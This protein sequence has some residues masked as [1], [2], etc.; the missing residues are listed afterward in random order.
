M[1]RSELFLTFGPA[2]E[3]ALLGNVQSALS[4][5]IGSCDYTGLLIEAGQR[6][7]AQLVCRDPAVVCGQPWFDKVFEVLDPTATV[8]WHVAEGSVVEPGTV[9]CEIDGFA[10]PMMTAERSAMNFLQLLS[11]VATCTRHYAELVKGT[12]AAVLDTRKTLP[13]LRLAQKYAV[14]VGGGENQ[15]LA[16]YDGILIKENHIATAGGISQALANADKV[17]SPG[18]TVQIE[19]ETLAQLDEALA[20]GATSVLLDNFT[21]EMMRDA[22]ARTAG[23]ALLEASGGVN[24][25][26]VRA[27]AE[28]GVDRIS[29]GALTKDVKATDYSLR[30]VA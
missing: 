17:R 16:L 10:R 26:T 27:I 11:A 13:G 18:V 23:R 3:M 21:L 19:V 20:A 15:R 22:V 9:V 4:E 6:C 2:L 25:S 24:E 12:R 7:R 5:D 1:S 8:L 30:V 28:T 14:R 29:V